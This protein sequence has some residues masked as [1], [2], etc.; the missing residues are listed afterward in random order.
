MSSQQAGTTADRPNGHHLKKIASLLK[1]LSNEKRI[2]ILGYLSKGERCVSELEGVVG[3]SQSALSQHLAKLRASE[4]VK[5]RR[6]AQNIYYSI[7]EKSVQDLIS[8]LTELK[9]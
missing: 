9:F 2:I 4:M 1:V 6:N 7:K 5:T 8:Y 3:L